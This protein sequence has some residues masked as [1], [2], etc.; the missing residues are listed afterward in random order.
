ME[1]W[2]GG[3]EG[4]R[5]AGNGWFVGE[6][7]RQGWCSGGDREKRMEG[8]GRRGVGVE[9]NIRNNLILQPAQKQNRHIPN[10]PDHLLGR[11]D[12]MAQRR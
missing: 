8:R 7:M 3:G 12:L 10:L 2:R 1:G 9:Q 4:E 6:V 11:P 5:R